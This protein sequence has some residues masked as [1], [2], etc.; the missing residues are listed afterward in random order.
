MNNIPVLTV[1]QINTYIKSIID[2]DPN[3]NY[4]FVVGEISNFTNHYRT[5]H[6]YF[7]LKDESS[8]IKA[9][10]FRSSAQRIKFVPENGMRVIL[11]GRVSVFERDGQ[12]QLYVDDMQPDGAGALN[13]AFEQLKARLE[14][15]GLFDASRKKP[16][17]EIP[18]RVGV[19]TSPTGAAVRDI[20]NVLGRRFP[21][22]KVVFCPVQV[23]GVSAAPQIA[24]AIDLFNRYNAADVLIVGRGGGSIEDLWAFN[25][26]QVALAVSRSSIPVIS[27]VGHETDFTI[28][29][30]VADLRAPT[31][32]AAA[33]LAVP[34]RAE[35]RAYVSGLM[36]H[37]S[38]LIRQEISE[39]KVRVNTLSQSRVLKNPLETV[40]IGR[41]T[42]DSLLNRLL[43]AQKAGFSSSVSRFAEACAKLDAL[44]P[45]K[46]LSRGYAAIYSGGK[47]TDSAEK[48]DMTKNISVRFA[49]GEIECKPLEKK[50]F[51]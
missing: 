49:D 33:E 39:Q 16:I 7:T 18:E 9:V 14:A 46:V 48:T 10:M 44:S 31:P 4:I 35:Q 28:C 24:Q 21:L 38:G 50:L 45:L 20:L 19:I 41:Q 32:S 47:I 25:E 8:A 6:Y 13:L 36:L 51:T 40:E 17:P 42:L 34:D 5:G 26:E 43:F 23:Q 2:G 29:D 3:L 15:Q 30:F 27:A 37:A 22:A 1:G 11:R 12:Y